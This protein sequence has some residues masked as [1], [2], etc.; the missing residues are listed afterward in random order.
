[1][2]KAF[3]YFDVGMRGLE[4]SIEN[5]S[6]D[7]IVDFSH[8]KLMQGNNVEIINIATGISK[9]I[10]ADNYIENFDGEFIYQYTDF[11]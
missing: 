5:A 9:Y 10:L 3:S 11:E 7:V 8:E 2:Y 4:D 6:F 1:M